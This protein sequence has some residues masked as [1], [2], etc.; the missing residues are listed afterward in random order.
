MKKTV[1]FG[2]NGRLA[3]AF[4]NMFPDIIA[5]SIEEANITD[6]SKVLEVV[7]KHRPQIIINCA[8][9]TD[10]DYCETHPDEVWMVN[11]RAV[12]NLCIAAKKYSALLVHYS[13]DYVINPVNEY[14]WTKLASEGLVSGVNGLVIRTTLYNET[15]WL[16]KELL[17]GRKVK[18]VKQRRFNPI[19]TYGLANITVQLAEKGARGT[20]YVGSRETVSIHDF[21]FDICE[22]FGVPKALVEL[23]DSVDSVKRLAPRVDDTSFSVDSL[24]KFGI[25][26]PTLKQDLESLKSSIEVR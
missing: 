20:V 21:A 14:A 26:P 4:Q 22:V 3:L 15:F 13:S 25:T 24:I 18:V 8:A 7:E 6:R 17:A 16:I 2:A 11:A 5:V 10:V 12:A 1:L 23:V 19:S 9:I